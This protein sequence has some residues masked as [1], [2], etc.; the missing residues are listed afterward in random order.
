MT[1]G[2]TSWDFRDEHELLISE[3]YEKVGYVIETAD[4]I[5]LESLKQTVHSAFEEYC[6]LHSKV[7]SVSLKMLTK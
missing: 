7:S 1:V 3:V 5:F 4:F 6:S 2:R